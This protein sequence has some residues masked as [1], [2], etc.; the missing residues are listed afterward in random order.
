MDLLRSP[1]VWRMGQGM[2]TACREGVAMT[3]SCL[4]LYEA[5]YNVNTIHRNP[6]LCF[7]SPPLCSTLLAVSPRLTSS[8]SASCSSPHCFFILTLLFQLGAYL[9]SLLIHPCSL[10]FMRSF[11]YFLKTHTRLVVRMQYSSV[12]SIRQADSEG[13]GNEDLI[14]PE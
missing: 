6:S 5:A 14:Q 1:L 11:S 3:A 9:F 2:E 13:C 10:R 12:F 4:A 8:I 7:S